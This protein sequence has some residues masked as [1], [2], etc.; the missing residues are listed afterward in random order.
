MEISKNKI[1]SSI[2]TIIFIY[3]KDNYSKIYLIT[4]ATMV[5]L[6]AENSLKTSKNC[7]M[8]VGIYHGL[9]ITGKIKSDL[10]KEERKDFEKDDRI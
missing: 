2:F 5:H 7:F 3:F 8:K 9:Q 1:K 4:C 10:K 6:H